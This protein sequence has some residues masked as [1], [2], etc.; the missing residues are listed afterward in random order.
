M[1]SIAILVNDDEDVVPLAAALDAAL[2]DKNIRAVACSRGQSV[3]QENDVRVFDV[4][5]IKG[6]EFEAVFFV[7]VDELANR[8]PELFDSTSTWE[9]RGPPTILD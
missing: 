9:R 1:P 5:R 6:L 4:Q 2:S 8:F 3:G 7:G